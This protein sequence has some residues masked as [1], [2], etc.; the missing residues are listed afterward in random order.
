MQCFWLE[1][2]MC[3]V[4]FYHLQAKSKKGILNPNFEK[5][6]KIIDIRVRKIIQRKII[7]ITI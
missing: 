7:E 3:L 6:M 5:L 4:K 2:Q 1:I